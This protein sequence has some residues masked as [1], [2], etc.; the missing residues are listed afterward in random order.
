[1]G[2][3]KALLPWRG[4]PLLVHMVEL[5]QAA[6]VEK[7]WVSAPAQQYCD[8]GLDSVAD[9]FPG[10]GPLGGIYSV[11]H[12][13][14]ADRLLV[15]ACDLPALPLALLQLLLRRSDVSHW[16]VAESAPGVTEPLCSVYGRDLL[17]ELEAALR[18][19]RLRVAA[20]VAAERK[21]V[22]DARELR[23]LGIGRE[24]FANLNSPRDFE[25]LAV[26]A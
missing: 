23:A 21:V 3:D 17:P 11:L 18:L 16:V 2:R 20:A 24:A 15:T 25:E 26:D 19:G 22:I 5:L 6:G 14:G 1:M 7:V 9:E 8:L 10:C 4:R 12:A 13:S